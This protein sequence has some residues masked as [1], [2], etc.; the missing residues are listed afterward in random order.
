MDSIRNHMGK[1]LPKIEPDAKVVEAAR[2]MVEN[3][4]HA[5]IIDE[6][7]R[8]VGITT[9]A[10]ISRKVVAKGQD[11]NQ[12]CVSSIMSHP[13]IMLDAKLSMEEAS[14]CLRKN[15]IR[16]IIVTENQEVTGTITFKIVS[17]YY[18]HKY[19]NGKDPVAEF[20]GNFDSSFYDE[21]EFRRTIEI[22]LEDVRVSIGDSCQTAEAIDNKKSPSEIARVARSEGLNDLA[23]ILEMV[24]ED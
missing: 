17:H 16:Q 12:V 9:E 24:D 13:V 20:W 23:Q 7:G 14:L 10:D 15:N 2:C 4:S 8:C 1:M 3:E 5:I 22:L 21:N 19:R 18:H 6:N 11:P